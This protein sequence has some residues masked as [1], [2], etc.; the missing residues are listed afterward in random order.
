MTSLQDQIACVKREIGMR[1]RVYPR[2]VQKGTMNP[3]KAERELA[4]MRDVLTTLESLT[5]RKE[6]C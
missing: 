2:F 4:T 5:T 6:G 1:E 3:D